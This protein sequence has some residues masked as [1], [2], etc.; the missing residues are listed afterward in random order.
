[1]APLQL[2]PG[3]DA[4]RELTYVIPLSGLAGCGH[5]GRRSREPLVTHVLPLAYPQ[6]A[7]LVALEQG[8][9]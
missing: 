9:A 8:Q 3:N 6:F 5:I 2:A 1:M 4:Q 7:K